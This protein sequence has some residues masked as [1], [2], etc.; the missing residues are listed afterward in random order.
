[1][2]LYMNDPTYINKLKWIK[3]SER[4]PE[5]NQFIVA[6]THKDTY[7]DISEYEADLCHNAVGNW[8]DGEVWEGG[9]DLNGFTHWMPLPP[10]CAFLRDNPGYL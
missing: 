9:N 10:V 6:I 5:R 8:I 2:S 3:F 1:M 7:E 4:E